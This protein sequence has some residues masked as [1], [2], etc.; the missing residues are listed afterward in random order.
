M[1][2]EEN[3]Q[4]IYEI[5]SKREYHE[6]ASK[7]KWGKSQCGTW[8]RLAVIMK[9]RVNHE[10]FVCPYCDKTMQYISIALWSN[11]HHELWDLGE[12]AKREIRDPCFPTE[13]QKQ[14]KQLFKSLIPKQMNRK[15]ETERKEIYITFVIDR[16]R[17]WVTVTM[18]SNLF[19]FYIGQNFWP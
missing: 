10:G 9:C 3:C 17:W 19:L 4:N 11:Y 12:A 5:L 18:T 6:I 1:P 7:C 14:R 13:V 15:R 8:N 2:V 16:D